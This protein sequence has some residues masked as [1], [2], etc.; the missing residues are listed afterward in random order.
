MRWLVGTNREH[1]RTD[2]WF[3]WNSVSKF[4][5][6]TPWAVETKHWNKLHIFFASTLKFCIHFS[7]LFFFFPLVSYSLKNMRITF[8]QFLSTALTA[9]TLKTM[10]LARCVFLLFI[11][12]QYDKSPF[13]FFCAL[14]ITVVPYSQAGVVNGPRCFNWFL[15]VDEWE[16]NCELNEQVW[17]G[18]YCNLTPTPTTVTTTTVRTYTRTQTDLDH[19]KPKR[20]LGPAGVCRSRRMRPEREKEAAEENKGDWREKE[21]F[22]YNNWLLLAI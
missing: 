1:F 14:S 12:A 17:L 2:M 5:S 6:G 9:L 10:S 15:T 13:L 16:S 19:T 21:R 20:N 4:L 11:F 18:N 3:W 22:K 7:H 8:L